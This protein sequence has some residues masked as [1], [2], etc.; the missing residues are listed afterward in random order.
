MSTDHTA[1]K[2]IMLERDNWK[3]MKTLTNVV[4]LQNKLQEE[5]SPERD[6]SPV[7]VSP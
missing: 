4:G 6:P 3:Y 5:Q 2:I 1:R 7:A